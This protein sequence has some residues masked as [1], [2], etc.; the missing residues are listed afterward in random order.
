[1]SFFSIAIMNLKIIIF[2]T[3]AMQS[4]LGFGQILGMP[5]LKRRFNYLE[6]L[7]KNVRIDKQPVFYKRFFEKNVI[8]IRHLGLSQSNLES[9]DTITNITSL[10]CNFLQ[11]ANQEVS[12]SRFFKA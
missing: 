7:N 3:I 6:Q 5:F 2:P 10:K 9:L 12:Y 4:G 8:S 11:W 1:M